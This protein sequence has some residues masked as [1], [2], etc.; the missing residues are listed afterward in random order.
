MNMCHSIIYNNFKS[1]GVPTWHYG[2]EPSNRFATWQAKFFHNA[3]REAGL[4]RIA[5]CGIIFS[6]GIY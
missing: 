1:I 6:P 3:I 5:N 4:I 2:H